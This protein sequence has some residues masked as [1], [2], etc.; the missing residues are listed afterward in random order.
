M[1]DLVKDLNEM[2]SIRSLISSKKEIVNIENV[3]DSI[4]HSI[5]KQRVESNAIIN[6]DIKKDATKIL[7]VKSWAW[8]QLLSE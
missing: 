2:L 6:V 1:D 5:E 3:I 4:F 7:T 8:E